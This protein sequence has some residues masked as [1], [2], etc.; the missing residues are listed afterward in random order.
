MSTRAATPFVV[1]KKG[2]LSAGAGS[3]AGAACANAPGAGA[4]VASFAAVAVASGERA[5]AFV[6]ATASAA[7]AGGAASVRPTTTASRPAKGLV[8]DDVNLRVTDYLLRAR[9]AS[10]PS[11]CPRHRSDQALEC[12]HGQQPPCRVAT[13]DGVRVRSSYLQRTC[14]SNRWPAARRRVSSIQASESSSLNRWRSR[15]AG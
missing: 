1:L 10:R 11:E 3:A 7:E 6:T 2:R 13:F 14:P 15:T 4:S 8:H 5:G 12:D 9:E